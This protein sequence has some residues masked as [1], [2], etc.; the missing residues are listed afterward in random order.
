MTTAL[1]ELDSKILEKLAENHDNG[2]R[3]LDLIDEL[4]DNYSESDVQRSLATL[5]S[6]H[7][8]TLTSKRRLRIEDDQTT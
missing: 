6:T 5:L 4:N 1:A 7:R 3:A 8:V 2:Y